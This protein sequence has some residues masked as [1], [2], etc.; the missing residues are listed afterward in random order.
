MSKLHLKIIKVVRGEWYE[1]KSEGY[2]LNGEGHKLVR[3][4][5]HNN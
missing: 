5:G 1:A 3:N 4:I 2:D